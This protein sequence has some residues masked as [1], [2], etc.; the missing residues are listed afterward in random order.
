MP[1]DA[2]SGLV[3]LMLGLAALA[4][5][6]SLGRSWKEFRDDDFTPRDR[7]LANQA[8]VF[9]V[10][11][12]V[13]LLH[14][15]GHVVAAVAVGARVTSFD[16]GF[17]EGSVGVAGNITRAEDLFV[18]LAGNVAG[19]LAGVSLLLV[20]TRA[21]SLPRA[22]R[23]LLLVGGLLEVGFTLVGYPVLSLTTRFGDWLVVYDFDSTPGLS[24]AVAVVHAA[25]LAGLWLWWRTSLR[26][27]VTVT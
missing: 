9:L 4:T 16:Y 2:S 7:S 22:V 8:A 5:A 14:E 10:P 1:V 19:A 15:L 3:D 23:H 27:A 13:V 24:L 6:V 18:A 17:F 26:A 25:V 20:G 12:V 21:R 11:P